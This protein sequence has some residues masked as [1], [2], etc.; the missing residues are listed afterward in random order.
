MEMNGIDRCLGFV[1]VLGFFEANGTGYM[2]MQYADGWTSGPT[3]SDSAVGCRWPWHSP[4]RCMFSMR[5]RC[6][7]RQP[8]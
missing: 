8:Q 7:D 6:C 1:T 3:S 5:W 2:V 4:S